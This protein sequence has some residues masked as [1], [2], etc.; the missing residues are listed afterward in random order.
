MIAEQ[1]LLKNGFRKIQK[2]KLKLQTYHV[3]HFEYFDVE[4]DAFV[5]WKRPSR[6]YLT[7]TNYLIYD[8]SSISKEHVER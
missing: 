3:T 1:F 8:T 7:T 4:S 5:F 6:E 2:L